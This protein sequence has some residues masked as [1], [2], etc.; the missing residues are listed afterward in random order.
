MFPDLLPAEGAA[1]PALPAHRTAA[2]VLFSPT[3][4]AERRFWEFFTAHIRNPN[5]RLAYLTAVRR[6]ADW[7]ERRGLALHQ[8]EPMVVAAYVKQHLAALRMLFDWLVVGQVLPF[9][10]AASVRGPKHV[11]KTG[12]TP[13][14]SA[15]ET[16]TLLDGIDL[17]TLAGL[18]DRALL[19]VLVYSFARV[20][21]AVSMRVADYYTQGPRSFFRLHEKGGR[22]NVVPAHHTAQAYVDAY[23]KAV[24]IGE[25]RRGPLFR[26]CEPGRRDALQDRAMSRLSALKMIKRRAGQ[27]GLP[28]EICAH[29]FRGAG[30]TEY[31]RNGRDLEVAA[32]IAG[33]ESTRTTQ[34]YNRLQEEISLDEIERIHI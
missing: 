32:R 34:L 33:H 18:R 31:L 28:T 30:I 26:S 23:L 10:P 1:R 5:T 15:T 20:S 24:G 8:V 14:L 3:A 17:S 25:D 6:F 27:A 22:Y 29:S 2:P 7:C 11:V 12:K 19:G 16:R 4:H 13:V 21:A 9:N